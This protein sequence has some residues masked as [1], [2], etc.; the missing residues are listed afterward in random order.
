MLP[1][2]YISHFIGVVILALTMYLVEKETSLKITTILESQVSFAVFCSAH[3]LAFV[4]LFFW[5]I[6]YSITML[7]V[8]FPKTFVVRT[9]RNFQF[10]FP[11]GSILFHLSFIYNIIFESN[12]CFAPKLVEFEFSLIL[13]SFPSKYSIAVFHSRHPFAYIDWLIFKAYFLND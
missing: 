13:V 3:P 2:S 1:F 8:V 10:P 4:F 9:I 7:F 6:K 12:S 11:E 5:P